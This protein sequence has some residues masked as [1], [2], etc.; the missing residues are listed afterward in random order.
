[1]YAPTDYAI[2]QSTYTSSDRKADGGKACLWW[3]GSPGSDSCGAV[4]VFYDGSIDNDGSGV[5]G[6]HYAVRP[7][8]RVRLF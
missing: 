8:V 1:M 6:N 5:N 7:Y 3:L 4:L 2:Q